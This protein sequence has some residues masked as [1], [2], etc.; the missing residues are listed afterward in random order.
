LLAGPKGCSYEIKIY[1]LDRTSFV[2]TQPTDFAHLTLSGFVSGSLQQVS[3]T[4]VSHEVVSTESQIISV[5]AK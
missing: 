3:V 4:I 5:R 2:W 1:N